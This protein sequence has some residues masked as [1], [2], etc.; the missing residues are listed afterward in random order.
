MV[1]Y[2][3][4]THRG[5]I[6]VNRL[7]TRLLTRESSVYLHVDQNADIETYNA[8]AA[9]VL[10]GDNVELIPR[11]ACVWGGWGIVEAI[12][13]GIR[14]I[15]ASKRFVQHIVIMS[16][17]CY[18]LRSA[19]AL[20]EFFSKYP[21]RCFVNSWEMPSDVLGSDGGMSRLLH[22]HRS[23]KGRRFRIPI[24][25]KQPNIRPYVGS[26]WM[27][28]DR[29]RATR[30]LD[31]T[32]ANPDIVRFYR[33]AWIPDEHYIQTVL[34]RF[35]LG[36]LPNASLWYIVWPK[37]GKKRIKSPPILATD[38]FKKLEEASHG[39]GDYQ[40]IPKLFARKFD[41]GVDS[42]VLNVIDS[43]LLGYP[44]ADR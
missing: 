28:L 8:I 26:T 13:V 11:V 36:N 4:L 41:I 24:A 16:G 3:I 33:H 12:L 29:N 25:R 22:W 42:N 39:E 44:L 15:L 19:E 21:D 32:D 43:K 35:D 18:P 37:S 30:L 6:Q 38:D 40:N 5:P 34:Q 14:K 10:R 31:F 1:A 9:N 7:V 27:V 20:V 23:I 17:Q 2:L